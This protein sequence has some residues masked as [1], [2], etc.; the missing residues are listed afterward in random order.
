MSTMTL[1]RPN[2]AFNTDLFLL[3]IDPK[4]IAT[5][6][7]YAKKLTTAQNIVESTG[8]VAAINASFFDPQGRPLGLL[9]HEGLMIQRIPQTGMFN[10]GVFCLQS[11]YPFIL[12][13]SAFKMDGVKEAI[14]S[15]PRLLHDGMIISQIKNKDEKKRRSGIAVDY[16]GK[17]IIYITDTHLGGL[18]FDDL[19]KFLISSNLNIRSALNL[20]GGRSSQLYLNYNN[21]N[22]NI[23]GL[24]EVPV[25]LAFYKNWSSL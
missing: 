7:I 17:I 10:S 1:K 21:R 16:N 25:F 5:K 18:S 9:V 12:H 3:R 23:V 8:A 20:D 6:V 13:R 15:M 19:Q 14:Q 4:F 22:K 24:S 11:N 2:I